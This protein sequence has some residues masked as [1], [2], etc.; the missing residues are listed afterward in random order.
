MPVN[1]N[2]SLFY[3]M[4]VFHCMNTPESLYVFVCGWTLRLF[5]VCQNCQVVSK[6]GC[7]SS[8]SHLY[9]VTPGCFLV[10]PASAIAGPY[11]LSVW[12]VANG[13]VTWL[14]TALLKF[15]V[16]NSEPSDP[17]HRD[18]PC[19]LHTAVPAP[20]RG[21]PRPPGSLAADRNCKLWCLFRD[22]LRGK[23]TS[24]ETKHSLY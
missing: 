10:L 1:C 6:S 9:G 24:L 13:G 8:H 23:S 16:L 14:E 22:A 11:I 5:P 2:S 17:S 12:W 19:K 21:P 18:V 20:C 3:L 15:G 4:T 7:G